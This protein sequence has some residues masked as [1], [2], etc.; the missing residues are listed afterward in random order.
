MKRLVRLLPSTTI[1]QQ[2][3]SSML[4]IDAV[5]YIKRQF[6]DEY[7]TI[8]TDDDIYQWIYDAETQIVRETGTNQSSVT[9]PCSAFP[10]SVPDSVNITRVTVKGVAIDF[11]WK[12]EL[13]M[14]QVS[15]TQTGDPAKYWY[16]YNKQIYLWP[17][18]NN[19]DQVKIWYSKLPVLMVGA[20]GANTF[21]VPEPYHND[22]V[23]FCLS[24]A[25]NK[26]QN[27]EMEQ[28]ELQRFEKNISTRAGE[29][30]G[31]DGPLFKIDDPMDFDYGSCW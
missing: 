19:S 23:K 17:D 21:S 20:A 11:I 22:I 25:H 2:K 26:D 31:F 24:R 7:A 27:V 28:L 1:V 30:H 12:D 8:I 5:R 4:V 9:Q 3:G 18:C 6:G 15:E 14:L 16:R 29:T 10:F 13:D